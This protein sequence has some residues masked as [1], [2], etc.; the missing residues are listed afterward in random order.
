MS[1]SKKGFCV[2]PPIPPQRLGRFPEFFHFRREG[3]TWSKPLLQNH[4]CSRLV[5]RQAYYQPSCTRDE[6]T[7]SLTQ[8]RKRDRRNP[9]SCLPCFRMRILLLLW[10]VYY[11]DVAQGSVVQ[12][13]ISCFSTTYG[14]ARIEAGCG[15]PDP[16]ET[17]STL[18][19]PNLVRSLIQY[20]NHRS[21][22]CR[23]A[24]SPRCEHSGKKI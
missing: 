23:C 10:L 3:G 22:S 11:F 24:A 8:A 6:T 4:L 5:G 1:L 15:V 18:A 12:P 2:T 19:T 16:W 20:N 9:V 21:G 13:S 7:H 14:T 17:T